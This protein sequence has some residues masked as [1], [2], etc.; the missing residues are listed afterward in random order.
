MTAVR[1]LNL[2]TVGDSRGALISECGLYRYRLWRR[3]GIGPHATWIMLNPSTADADLDDPTIRRC[4]GFA[5]A[6]GFSAIEVV[7]LFALRATNPRELGR[8]ADPIGPDNDRHLSEAGRAAELRIAAWGHR[9]LGI[10]PSAFKA[11][12]RHR[13]RGAGRR[14]SLPGADGGGTAAPPALPS[15]HGGARAPVRTCPIHRVQLED[16][17]PCLQCLE[18]LPPHMKREAARRVRWQ[19]AYLLFVVVSGLLFSAAILALNLYREWRIW[20]R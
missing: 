20:Y 7:N 1:Q 14:S 19:V 15:Q 17:E 12:D 2:A 16:D 5:R 4:I 10:V 6:W 8:S 11:E 18:T 3:W 9:P 13:A